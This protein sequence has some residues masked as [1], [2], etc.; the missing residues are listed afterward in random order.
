MTVTL[1]PPAELLADPAR[2]LYVCLAVPWGEPADPAAEIPGHVYHFGDVRQPAD[3][4]RVSVNLDHGAADVVGVGVQ[5]VTDRAGLWCLVKL[6][7][8]AVALLERGA[9]GVSAE[10]DEHGYLSGVALVTHGRPS[11]A[12]AR[13]FDDVV[14]LRFSGVASPSR[15]REPA[16]EH[17]RDGD[18]ALAGM[19]GGGSFEIGH[20]P[21]GRW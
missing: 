12:S 16:I 8:R 10:V 4:H 1:E 5:T 14:P 15:R 18:P 3:P 20:R 13:L 17:R 11:F 9:S 21:A 6:G 19:F 7:R 2:G